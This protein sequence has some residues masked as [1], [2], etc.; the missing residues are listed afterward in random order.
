[1]YIAAAAAALLVMLVTT[2]LNGWIAT[3]VVASFTQARE[4]AFAAFCYTVGA[5]LFGLPRLI[6]DGDPLW[7]ILP[8][9]A[10][11]AL[12][13]LLLWRRKVGPERALADAVSDR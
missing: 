7:M 3:A 12:G 4:P 10:G 9:L 6:D 5:M 11:V 8:G 1:M 2:L 13:L